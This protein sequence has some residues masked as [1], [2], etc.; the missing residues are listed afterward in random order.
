MTGT[1]YMVV[2]R[3]VQ[4]HGWHK[5]SCG[6]WS[7]LC[8]GTGGIQQVAREGLGCC[9]CRS[10]LHEARSRAG[11]VHA[12]HVLCFLSSNTFRGHVY[13]SKS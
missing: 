6:Q 2:F 9:S 5:H 4:V 13:C 12:H 11:Q 8:G 10:A 1:W 3:C 7:V